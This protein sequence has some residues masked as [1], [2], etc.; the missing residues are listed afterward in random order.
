VIDVI[1]TIHLVH[2]A[3]SSSAAPRSLTGL[4]CNTAHIWLRSL[5]AHQQLLVLTA[6]ADVQ[7]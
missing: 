3:R 2:V 7:P 4:A 1:A 5:T 6:D